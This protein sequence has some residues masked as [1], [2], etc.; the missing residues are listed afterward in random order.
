MKK[1]FT[2]II[3]LSL[4][5][6]TQAQ[7]LITNP[8]FETNFTGWSSFWSRDGLG[9]ATIISSPVHGGSKA[10]KIYYPSS[11]DWALS[12]QNKT[13]VVPGEVYELSCWIKTDS[14]IG[15]SM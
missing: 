12:V 4:V 15:G 8:G 9:A 2:L 14:I 6:I 3:C 7:N 13:I 5:T 11:Q 10:V 1:V